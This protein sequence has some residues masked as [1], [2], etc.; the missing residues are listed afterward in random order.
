MIWI[1]TYLEDIR[2]LDIIK[3]SF[4]SLFDTYWIWDIIVVD[5]C[6]PIKNWINWLK[7]QWVKII[8]RQNNWWYAKAKNTL[9]KYFMDNW[10][11]I[12]FLAD[13]DNLYVSWRYEQYTEAIKYT[14]YQHRNLRLSYLTLDNSQQPYWEIREVNWYKYRESPLVNWCFNSFTRETIDKIGYFNEMPYKNWHEHSFFTQ[15]AI[16]NWFAPWYIDVLEPKIQN[17]QLIDTNYLV[18]NKDAYNDEYL[19]ENWKV[20]SLDKNL[21]YNF[22]D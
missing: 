19:N 7:R 1:T 4:E 12:W 3:K 9:L 8:E 22:H 13:D 18:S 15:R 20:F 21:Y 16:A 6:S 5:D 2:R 17:L 11:D 10:Q 14:W